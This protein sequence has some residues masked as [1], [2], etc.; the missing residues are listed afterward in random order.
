[1]VTAFVLIQTELGRQNGVAIA[2]AELPGVTK[3]AVLTGP[4]DVIAEV[5]AGDVDALGKLVYNG[6]QGVPG[7][8][9]TVTCPVLHL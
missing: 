8:T 4:Y 5:A 2:L 3:A 1:M 6:I 7:V 9:R